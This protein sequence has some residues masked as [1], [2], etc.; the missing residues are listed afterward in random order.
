MEKTAMI[1]MS[2]CRNLKRIIGGMIDEEFAIKFLFTRRTF[3]STNN[4]FSFEFRGLIA[5]LCNTCTRKSVE[6]YETQ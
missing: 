6:V 3:C 2:L 4:I 5:P 1:A